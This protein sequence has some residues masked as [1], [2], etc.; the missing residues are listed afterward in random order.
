MNQGPMENRGA[1]NDVQ[2]VMGRMAQEL[3]AL[4]QQRDEVVRKI[5]T[6]KKTVAGLATL[7]GPG[8]MQEQLPE[9]F[10]QRPS[11]R[12]GLSDECRLALM[13][14]ERPLATREVVDR[15]ARRLPSLAKHRDP[16]AS[17]TTILNRL[18]RYGE[19][20]RVIDDRGRQLWA[21]STEKPSDTETRASNNLPVE[22]ARVSE[23]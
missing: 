1:I 7:F 9:L 21:W 13:K 15:V 8:E 4:I 2:I 10:S 5:C 19:A 14:A 6:V 20:C 12:P 11:R 22:A 18:I 17:V 3:Q 16:M 23:L